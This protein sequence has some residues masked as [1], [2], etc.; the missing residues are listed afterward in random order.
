MREGGD[1]SAPD[2]GARARDLAVAG[3]LSGAIALLQ[4]APADQVA[5]HRN[6]LAQLL[7]AAEHHEEALAVR[8]AQA[9]A[10]PGVAAH[11]HNVAAR[12]GDMGRAVE[13]EAAVRRAFA[14]GGDAPETWLVLARALQGQDRHDE[15]EAA[16]AETLK[17]R[18]DYLDA[19]VDQS[20][21]IWMRTGDAE[22]AREP[23]NA[24]IA[25]APNRP[26]LYAARAKLDRFT[27]ASP[28]VIH[29][30]LTASP[31][32]A[33]GLIELAAAHAALGFD[34]DRALAH[35][36][37]ALAQTPGD[38][39]AIQQLVEIHLARNEPAAALALL[40]PLLAQRPTDQQAIAFRHTAW[41][42]AGDPRALTPADY[43][44]VVAGHIIDTPPGWETLDAYLADLARALAPLHGLT[45]H[46]VGQSLRHGTQTSVD[47]RHSDDPAIRAFFTAIDG[48]IRRHMAMLGQGD[49]P[50]RRRNTGDYRLAGCWSVR[51]R[52]GGFHMP[53]FHSKGWLSSAC[54]IELPSAVEGEGREGWLAFGSPPFEIGAFEGVQPLP[55]D[56]YEKPSPGRL[57]L[58]PSYMWHGTVPFSGTETRLTIAFDVVPA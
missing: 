32:A 49:D 14:L 35:A 48:P 3:D 19:L 34:R 25:R 24:A 31:V 37:A 54:H 46:P 29:R 22:R 56:H 30:D 55:P 5:G 16:F 20:Q 53:H 23:L 33:S 36:R 57:V 43:A 40:D 10:E 8:L 27:G 13:A 50:L 21:L 39:A 41:R 58:F 52:P 4:A 1:L 18:S 44:A 9:E 45:E 7:V 15:A 42:L 17:R 6:M 26:D 47:L 2:R 38:P 12:L 28:E 51:L 11:Q